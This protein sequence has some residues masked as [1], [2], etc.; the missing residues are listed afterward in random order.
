MRKANATTS[1]SGNSA[2]T[3]N[4][5]VHAMRA[6]SDAGCGCDARESCARAMAR[7]TKTCP[8]LAMRCEDDMNARG[9]ARDACSGEA[10]A[11]S[12]SLTSTLVFMLAAA[13]APLVSEDIKTDEDFVR[14]LK[15][16]YTKREFSVP[17]RDGV[18][19]H[20]HV[21]TPKP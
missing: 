1:P 5:I 4:A 19:L 3:G 12:I 17:M 8:M 14:V 6:R 15:E 20:T 21:W 11:M 13:P 18:K 16:S 9:V 10:R 7:P 2:S